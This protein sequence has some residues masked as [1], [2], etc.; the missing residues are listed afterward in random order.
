[1]NRRGSGAEDG[2][3]QPPQGNLTSGR[4]R[5]LALSKRKARK[6]A[7]LCHGVYPHL[8]HHV[9][10]KYGSTG[11]HAKKTDSSYLNMVLGGHWFDPKIC[12]SPGT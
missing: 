6:D 12:K 3:Q 8:R 1:M 5:R 7:R 9:Q 10:A 2:S 4:V 11:I